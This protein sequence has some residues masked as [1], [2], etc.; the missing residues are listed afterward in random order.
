MGERL[1]KAEEMARKKAGQKQKRLTPPEENE[2]GNKKKVKSDEEEDLPAWLR[3]HIPPSE[4]FEAVMR[5][6]RCAERIARVA[7]D[8]PEVRLLRKKLTKAEAVNCDLEA[9]LMDR[10]DK[11]DNFNNALVPEFIEENNLF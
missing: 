8:V 6:F 2:G 1:K 7:D 4:D 3:C 10:Q 11:L 5:V 9:D